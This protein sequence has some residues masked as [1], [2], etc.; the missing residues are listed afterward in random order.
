M[1]HFCV[2][3][4]LLQHVRGGGELGRHF[5]EPPNGAK[6]LC[7]QNSFNDFVDVGRFLV[8]ERQLTSTDL[9]ACLGAS[10]GGLLIGASINQAPELFKAAVLDV[11]FV[12]VMGTMVDGS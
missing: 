9:L 10:A 2:L 8:Q 12:D 6:Y 11:P 4:G 7:K 3:F 1:A 5:Y